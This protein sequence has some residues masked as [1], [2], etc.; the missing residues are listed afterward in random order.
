LISSIVRSERC[1]ENEGT[2]RVSNKAN[3]VAKKISL[4]VFR[5]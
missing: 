5:S 4:P 1:W 3:E 2:L